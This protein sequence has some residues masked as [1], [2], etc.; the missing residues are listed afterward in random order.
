MK[1]W[2][3]AIDPSTSRHPGSG[4]HWA[5]LSRAHAQQSTFL[6]INRVTTPSLTVISFYKKP[7]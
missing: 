3:L 7:L 6:G 2:G 5:A 4:G 1:G